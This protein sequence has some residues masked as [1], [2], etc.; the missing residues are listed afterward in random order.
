MDFIDL[1]KQQKFIRKELEQSIV[2]VLDSGQYILGGEVSELEEEL[3]H[4]TSSKFCVGVSSGTDALLV[5][6]MALNISSGDEVITS[7]FSYFSTVEVILSLGAIPIFVDIRPETF[8]INE[9]NISKVITDK[10][11]A[12]MPVSLFGQCPDFDLIN[13]IADKHNLPV[14]EDA[15][16]SFGAEFNGNK[17][18]NL[19]TIG[20]TSFFPSKPLGGYGD[21][22]ACFTNDKNL[23]DKIR[24]ISTHGQDKKYHH[25]LIG[26]NA[27]MDTIQAAILLQKLKLFPGEVEKR[28]KIGQRYT[29]EIKK[30]ENI[31]LI[32]PHVDRKNKSVYAQYTIQTNQRDEVIQKFNEFN[33]PFAINYPMPLHKQDALLDYSSLNL[34]VSEKLSQQVISL[35]MHP[36]LS[37]KDQDLILTVLGSI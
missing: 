6:L 7:P 12:I 8:N 13:A 31:N 10:T 18:C 24:K 21:S 16:Q 29:E 32:S 34:P 9:D 14:I 33:I 11:R 23:A 20:C 25:S 19:S 2:S 17:S 28:Q 3:S 1:N 15:A 27:R 30:L 4:Y 5:S 22:G 35:P 36:Y 37:E 26:L